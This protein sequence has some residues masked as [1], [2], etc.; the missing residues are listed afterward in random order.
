[1]L[2]KVKLKTPLSKEDVRRLK[3]GD[4]VYL[5][6]RKVYVVAMTTAAKY[7][8]DSI[9]NGHPIF[10]LKGSVIYHCPCGFGKL[11]GDY[12]LRWVGATTSIMN[13]PVTPKLIELGANVIMGKGGMGKGTLDAM[14][15]HGA[16][17]LATVGATS[18]V[19]AR[20]VTKVVK[21]ID[22]SIWLSELEVKDFGP[23]IVGMDAHGHNL[24]EDV[25]E[26]AREKAAV[27]MG[28]VT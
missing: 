18:A 12:K 7:L 27:L 21:M 15:K 17:Y 11:D 16:V 24:F 19:L 26:R 4:M 22:P 25:W 10:D 8:L 13:E 9:E 1:M 5:T 2:K 6:G 3:I 20:R 28:R 23:T 14:R